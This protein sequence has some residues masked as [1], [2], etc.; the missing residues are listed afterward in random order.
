MYYYSIA[1]LRHPRY[2]DRKYVVI[3]SLRQVRIPRWRYVLKRK[4]KTYIIYELSKITR[5]SY[6]AKE[7]LRNYVST[8][9]TEE[10]FRNVM[11]EA[12]KKSYKK[13]KQLRNILSY[14]M[15]S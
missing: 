9:L 12:I 7:Y 11:V 3:K 1:I 15:T 4:R 10:E 8:W 13:L 14:L 2:S 6:E 5:L